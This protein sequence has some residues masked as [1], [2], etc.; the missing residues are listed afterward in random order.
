MTIPQYR[1]MFPPLVVQEN[2]PDTGVNE[3][4]FEDKNLYDTT[5]VYTIYAVVDPMLQP[6]VPMTFTFPHIPQIKSIWW[7]FSC[8]T[9]SQLSTVNMTLVDGAGSQT[10]RN[11]KKYF[12]CFCDNF[13][14]ITLQINGGAGSIKMKML[15]LG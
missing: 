12:F 8:P 1:V 14:S 7:E 3:T 15:V 13:Q 9:Q 6:G 10:I 5:A 4:V 11:L 2:Y